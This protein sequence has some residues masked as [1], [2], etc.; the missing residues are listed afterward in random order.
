MS[1]IDVVLARHRPAPHLSI[2]PALG[3]AQDRLQE[4]MI[5]IRPAGFRS[6]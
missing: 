6:R 5:S 2:A 4:R 3:A 1:R